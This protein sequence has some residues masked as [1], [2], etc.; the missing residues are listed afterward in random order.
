METYNEIKVDTGQ[1]R[2]RDLD[3]LRE[4]LRSNSL[5]DLARSKDASVGNISKQIRSLEVRLGVP[6]VER[7]AQGVKPT[8]EA[9]RIQPYLEKFHELE[10]SLVS[11]FSETENLERLTIATTST[12]STC[13]LPPVLSAYKSL[14]ENAHFRLLEMPP[15]NFL[16]TALRGGFQVCLHVGEMDWPRTWTSAKIGS[17]TW[18]LFGKKGHP[19]GTQASV[20]EVKK[21]P[22][23]MPTY[24][25]EHGIRFG[26]DF[27]PIPVSKRKTGSETASAAAALEIVQRTSQ[28]G[29][30]LNLTARES[31]EANRL[32]KIEVK[33]WRRVRKDLYLSVKNDSVSQNA[34]LTLQR[35]LREQIT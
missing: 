18:S 20:V 1:I 31:V 15:A 28:L 21:Y 16:S 26:N 9:M 8:P 25:S 22:F 27:C 19:L 17:L 24:W 11:E 29:F 12:L 34:F 13:L 14:K 30:F 2:L 33:S 4:L 7:S 10:E 32:Q 35:M 5:R 23:V 3:L 6:L